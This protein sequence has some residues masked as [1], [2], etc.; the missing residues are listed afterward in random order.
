LA[1]FTNG[2][3]AAQVYQVVAIAAA[4]IRWASHDTGRPDSQIVDELAKNFEPGDQ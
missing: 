3:S 1:A 4:T 2:A